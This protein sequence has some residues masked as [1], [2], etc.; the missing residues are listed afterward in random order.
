MLDSNISLRGPQR[1]IIDYMR[2][3]YG[4]EDIKVRPGGKHIHIE[5]VYRG[6]THKDTLPNGHAVDPNWISVRK[7][8]LRKELG[9]PPAVVAPPPRRRS[10]EEMTQEA[11][12]K[13]DLLASTA[14]ATVVLPSKSSTV[15]PAIPAGMGKTAPATSPIPLPKFACSVGSLKHS[16]D[17]S[18]YLGK[19]LGDAMD[20]QFGAGRRYVIGYSH[21]GLWTAR[22]SMTDGRAIETNHRLHCRGSETIKKLGKFQGTKCEAMLHHNRVEFRLAAPVE[23]LKPQFPPT[24]EIQKTSEPVPMPEPHKPEPVASPPPAD[25]RERLRSVLRQIKEIE[26]EGTYRLISENGWR[27]RANDIGL[28]D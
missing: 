4:I 19:E 28:E 3:A 9:D 7:H 25:P 10:L 21:P 15:I 24:G 6:Q 13:A 22:P 11:Q 26:E 8:D 17:I 23:L 18:F 1:E 2:T 27:W 20:T 14:I 12:A 5:Y 16:N